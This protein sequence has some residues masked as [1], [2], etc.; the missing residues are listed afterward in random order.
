MNNIIL[1][2]P[3]QLFDIKYYKKVINKNDI[4]YL[5]EDKYFFSKYKYHKL[6]LILHRSSMKYYYN[7]LEKIFKNINYIEYNKKEEIYENIKK[8]KYNEIVL[9][10]PI[11]KEIIKKLENNFKNI[12][13]LKS[14]M[15]LNSNEDNIEINK[16]LKKIRHDT[17]Y[18]LQRIKYDIL[19]DEN[20]KPLYNKWS[21]DRENRSK[22]PKDIKEPENYKI[23]QNNKYIIEAKEYIENNFKNHYGKIDNFIFPI[24]R[25]DAIKWLK[26]FINN[27]LD[28]FGKYEDGI[29]ENIIIG[30]HS[31]LSPMLNI[32]LITSFDIL[33][34]IKKIKINKNNISTIEGFIR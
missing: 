5:I 28:L 16:Q 20:N 26:F 2:Y 12:K 31:C 3:T 24:N 33:K 23:N 7:E 10:D 27:K 18:K 19:I 25:K 14:P 1:I 9:Y 30:Y 8:I 17:F 4:I 29:N 11:E 32:G 13:L 34:E 22:Y 6:K 21:F 15:F